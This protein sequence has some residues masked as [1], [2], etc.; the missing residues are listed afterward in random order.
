MDSE[1]GPFGHRSWASVNY[2]G[3]P[4][5]DLLCEPTRSIANGCCVAMTSPACI[6]NDECG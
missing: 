1:N 3:T 2:L 5:M 4:R 6:W